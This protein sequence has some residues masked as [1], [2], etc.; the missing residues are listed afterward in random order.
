MKGVTLRQIRVFVA[1]AHHLSFSRAA[2]M[3]SLTPPAV[4]MQIRE[5][6][7]QIGLPLFDREGRNVSLTITGEYFLVYARKVLATLKDAE[8]M[9]AHFKRVETGRLVIGMVSTAQYFVPPLLGRFCQDHPGVEV[10]L[11]VGNRQTLVEQLQRNEVDLAVM[12]RPSREMATRAE[13]FA[14]H[15]HVFVAAPDHPLVRLGHVPAEALAGYNFIVREPGSGTRA[16][17]EEYWK[18][19]GLTPHITME[20]SGNETIKQAV[21][22]NMGIS[23]LSLHTLGLELSNERIAI[24]DVEGAPVL[25][26][27]HMANLLSKV[28]SPPAEAFRYFMLEHA[29]E[30]LRQEFGHV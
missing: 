30:F 20:M 22:A 16:V 28:L 19:H 15:P 5:L 7:T 27:W 21:M 10:S 13:P 8:D 9:V 24:I 11:S 14:V 17:L 29:E 25:R 1:V 2:D 3:L 26:R 23:L 4:T 12:G 6:E 18:R